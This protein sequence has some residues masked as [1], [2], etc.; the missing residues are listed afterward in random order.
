M[1]IFIQ[2]QY[3]M[4]RRVVVSTWERDTNTYKNWIER[5]YSTT[6]TKC[7]EHF[8]YALLSKNIFGS[9]IC[10][11]LHQWLSLIDLLFFWKIVMESFKQ[12]LFCTSINSLKRIF[13]IFD[14]FYFF[15]ITLGKTAQSTKLIQSSPLCSCVP[16]DCWGLSILGN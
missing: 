8:V 1:Y 5:M 16:M 13:G 2:F 3:S 14:K 4:I 12:K 11:T 6:N 10:I 7:N 9:Q 15:I